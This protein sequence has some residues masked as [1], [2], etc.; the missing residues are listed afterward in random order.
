MR[1]V[2]PCPRERDHLPFRKSSCCCPNARPEGAPFPPAA[3]SK[4]IKKGQPYGCPF[5]V[6]R[7]LP[8]KR[9]KNASPCFFP[10]PDA[11]LASICPAS[12]PQP[13]QKKKPDQHGQARHV[14]PGDSSSGLQQAAFPSSSMIKRVLEGWGSL[15]GKRT[16]SCASQK[17]PLPPQKL[18]TLQPIPVHPARTGPDGRPPVR[19]SCSCCRGP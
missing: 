19:P 8:T 3:F 16:F 7:M 18:S 12:F 14:F 4:A 2:L 11:F 13:L 9:E 15:K 1:D 17:V 5:Y 10:P 6:Q